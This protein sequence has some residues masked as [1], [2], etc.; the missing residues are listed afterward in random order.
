M[1][2]GPVK[3][4]VDFSVGTNNDTGLANPTSVQP[5][6][7]GE[8]VD[9]TVANRGGESLRQRTEEIRSIQTDSLFLQNAD[10]VLL[11]SGPGKVTWP[12]STTAAAS[13]IPVLSDTLWILPM[14]TPGFPQANPIP[15]VASAFGVIH[16]KRADSTNC[17]AVTSQRRSYAAG[18]QINITVTPGSVYSCTLQTEDTGFLRRTIAIVATNTTTLGTVIASLNGLIPP[19][20]DNT[21]LVSAALEGGGLAGDLI[22]TSQARQYMSGNYDGE[23]HAIT[24][25]NLAAFFAGNPT[26]ALAEGDTLCVAYAD[27][28]DTASNGGRRQSIPENANTAI[29]SG[30]FFNSRVHPELLFGSL[31]I[32]KVV[33]GNLVF[34]T[35]IEIGAGQINTSLSSVNTLSPLIRNGDFEHGVTGSTGRFGISDWE[36]RFDLQVNGSFQLTATSPIAGGKSLAFINTAVGAATARIEQEQELEVSPSQNVTV[37]IQIK[38]LIAPTAGTISVVLY[39]GDQDSTTVTSTTIALQSIGTTDASARTVQQTVTVPAGKRFIKMVTVEVAGVTAAST[40][41]LA[42]FDALQ[43]WIQ[44]ATATTIAAANNSHMRPQILDALVLEDPNSYSLGQLA[45]LMRFDRTTPASEGTAYLERKDQTYDASHLPPAHAIFGR[46][47]SLGSKLLNSAAEA[48][49][50]PRISA[51]FLTTGDL[52]LI[53]QSDPQGGGSEG[54]VRVYVSL[55]GD[56]YITQNASF[57]G[58]NFNKDV[59]GTIAMQFSIRRGHIDMHAM[60]ADAAWSTW[61]QISQFNISQQTGVSGN[62]NFQPLLQLF[63]AGN[64]QRVGFDHLGFRATQNI[65]LSE[66]WMIIARATIAAGAVINGWVFNK[67]GSG[68][69]IG[70]AYGNATL[71]PRGYAALEQTISSGVAGTVFAAHNNAMLFA[72]AT[73]HFPY[74]DMAIVVEFEQ[75]GAGDTGA[76]PGLTMIRGLSN[77]GVQGVYFKKADGSANWKFV[78]GDNGGLTNS[79]DTGVAV[80]TNQRFRIEVYGSNHPGGQRA[81]GYINGVLVGT[82]T[83][84]MPNADMQAYIST[85]GTPVANVTV[86]IGPFMIYATRALAH[87]SL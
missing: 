17:I 16:L 73:G 85:F 42:L 13:G 33:N 71:T 75:D 21:Q 64:N 12:G 84:H 83:T 72:D 26:Q 25:A 4:F 45:A 15:P 5:I 46:I 10:R 76:S 47:L 30:S 7:D 70:A 27:L 37:S 80:A 65:D 3:P 36:N 35:G 39:W 49:S 50:K 23:G 40:G 28:F 78:T 69:Q 38:Q 61:N 11:I 20:P 51:P 81:C 54:S 22:L 18:D 6:N 87:D 74:P 29:P 41:T 55:N 43:V 53:F 14:L 67:S 57:D 82:S 56:L 31:P 24:P 2:S 8:A 77:D 52:T 19:A 9:A 1:S 68:A 62:S 58:T 63:D 44:N 34:S 60:V 48:R 59:T 86:D 79:I 66:N 32:C